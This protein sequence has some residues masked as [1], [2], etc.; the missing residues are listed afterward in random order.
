MKNW[1]SQIIIPDPELANR[2]RKISTLI[3]QAVMVPWYAFR[4]LCFEKNMRIFCF[5]KIYIYK[6]K[7]ISNAEGRLSAQKL[8]N[9]KLHLFKLVQE[10]TFP[11]K[12]DV[13]AV[14][15]VLGQDGTSGV[16]TEP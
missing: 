12:Q 7:K 5:V 11:K 1:A 4:Y 13:I 6:C 9:G 8:I 16:S 2:E 15:V 14:M 3:A 10:E